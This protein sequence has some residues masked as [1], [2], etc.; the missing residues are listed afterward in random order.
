MA[1]FQF[2]ASAG[3]AVVAWLCATHAAELPFWAPLRTPA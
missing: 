1:D 2:A 3:G